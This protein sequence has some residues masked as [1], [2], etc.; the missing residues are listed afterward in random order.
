MLKKVNIR[1]KFDSFTD[2]WQPKILATVNDFALKAVKLDG[3][4]IWHHHDEEDE[5]FIVVRGRIDMHYRV[6]GKEFVE[7]FGENEL[8]RVP[9]G[10]EHKPAAAPG[11]ELLLIERT[12]TPNV[13]NVSDSER[14]AE[15]QFIGEQ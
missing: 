3:D 4:F 12:A 14:R 10:V 6:D 13:G 2:T 7:S 9:R 15:P 5:I 11:T 1:E 8:L